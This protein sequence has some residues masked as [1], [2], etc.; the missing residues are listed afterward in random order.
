MR[1]PR[2][3]HDSGGVKPW[4]RCQS[5]LLPRQRHTRKRRL[6]QR[7]GARFPPRLINR[8]THSQ[9]AANIAATSSTSALHPKPG[10]PALAAPP[11]TVPSPSARRSL[12]AAQRTNRKRS[13]SWILV[14][15]KMAGGRPSGTTT[16]TIRATLVV[17]G[18]T[19][20]PVRFQHEVMPYNSARGIALYRRHACPL[21]RS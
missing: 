10:R 3:L 2:G 20:E 16:T 9:P 19:R 11:S 7:E 6:L 12:A 1:V 14:W 4:C 17:H 13:A 21:S 8:C 18:A 15:K 5:L